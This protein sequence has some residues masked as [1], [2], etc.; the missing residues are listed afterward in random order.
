MPRSSN[1]LAPAELAM[2]EPEE[3]IEHCGGQRPS[4]RRR[5]FA[6]ALPVAL[7][8]ERAGPWVATLG[9]VAVASLVLWAGA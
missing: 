6:T 9:L 7:G 3:R 4:P 8:A 5:D 2:I 1:G